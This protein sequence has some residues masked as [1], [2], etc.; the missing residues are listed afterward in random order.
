MHLII[1]AGRSVGCWSA[2]SLC[3]LFIF[4][5]QVLLGIE[6]MKFIGLGPIYAFVTVLHRVTVILVRKLIIHGNQHTYIRIHCTTSQ[7]VL[8]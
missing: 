4:R 3:Y 5:Y 2:A 6:S 1:M 7:S 8:E